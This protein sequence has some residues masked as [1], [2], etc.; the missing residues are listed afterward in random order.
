MFLGAA[1]HDQDFPS[2]P[3]GPKA[4][5][6]SQRPPQHQQFHKPEP[7]PVPKPAPKREPDF[8]SLG[9]D[10]RRVGSDNLLSNFR[11]ADSTP[12]Y[13]NLPG[14]GRYTLDIFARDIAIKRYC[15]IKI[16]LSHGFLKAKVSS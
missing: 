9:S 7:K 1:F 12:Q 16:I 11:A 2:L 15:D 6:S 8:P 3:G 5:S 4:S 14:K 13:R 10:N